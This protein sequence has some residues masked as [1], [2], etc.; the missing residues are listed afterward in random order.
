MNHAFL[1]SVVAFLA[2][3]QTCLIAGHVAGDSQ[4]MPNGFSFRY[5][6]T[7]R[8]KMGDNR[9]DEVGRG[10]HVPVEVEISKP[11]WMQECEVSMSQWTRLMK[12]E[13]WV[14]Q[15]SVGGS[16][17]C[18]VSWVSYDDAV[19]FCLELTKSSPLMPDGAMVSYH[20]PTEAEWEYASRAGAT[21]RYCF[22][23]SDDKLADYAVFASIP[24][25]P[26]SPSPCKSKLPNQWGIYDMHGNVG[27]WCR[28]GYQDSLLGGQDPI[29]DLKL[30]VVFRGGS[31][32]AS[33]DYCRS[34]TRFYRVKTDKIS[35]IGFRV[36]MREQGGGSG[37]TPVEAP[38]PEKAR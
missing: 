24:T 19:S 17:L 15:R 33:P 25:P 4:V 5:C 29:A 34:T 28:D 16:D 10:D 6:P 32:S 22:G 27:E 38:Q 1:L 8:F 9:P 21:S 30:R 7:G 14:G 13:P 12:T 20:L 3:T 18:P 36:V 23:D 11:F 31:F 35:T 26:L 37:G 2:M